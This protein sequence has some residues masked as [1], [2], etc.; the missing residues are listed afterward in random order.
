[1]NFGQLDQRDALIGIKE[2]CGLRKACGVRDGVE[3]T[4]GRER[5]R[6]W[7][8]I[9]GNFRRSEETGDVVSNGQIARTLPEVS[10]RGGEE[11]G[12]GGQDRRVE[13]QHVAWRKARKVG[14]E[15]EARRGRLAVVLLDERHRRKIGTA[16]ASDRRG[17][18]R[19]GPERA[20]RGIC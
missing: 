12:V 18:G 16:E 9:S 7:S 6:V 20:R 10:A 14:A 2:R 1:M 17:E 15:S 4:D 13:G 5:S 8:G 11:V 3:P 19:G